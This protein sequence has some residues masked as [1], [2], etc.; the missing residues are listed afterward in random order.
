MRALLRLLVVLPSAL[1]LVSA[2]ITTPASET[3]WSRRARMLTPTACDESALIEDAEDGDTQI[4]KRAGRGGYWYTFADSYGSRVEPAPF[5]PEGPGH[6]GSQRA[7]H[8]RGHTAPSAPE[9]Y[10]YAGMAFSLADPRGDYDASRYRGVSFW[11]KGPAHIRFEIPDGYTSPEGGYCKDCYNDFSIELALSGEWQRYT[12]LFS[13][14]A[15]RQGWGDPRPSISPQRLFALEWE[16]S[17]PDRDF[18]V[19]I[20]DVAFVCGVQGGS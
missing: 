18:D 11:A 9:V 7:A 5:K 19:W 14:L 16:F 1:V 6:D 3:G 2:C 20:D 10:P 4:L 15:Q 12:I 17:T 8:M 13:W